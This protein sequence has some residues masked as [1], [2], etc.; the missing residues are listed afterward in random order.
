M[1]M[2]RERSGLTADGAC[3]IALGAFYNATARHP[4][5]GAAL[6]GAWMEEI[7]RKLKRDAAVGLDYREIIARWGAE[8]N[9]P[10]NA[11]F[12]TIDNRP[13]NAATAGAGNG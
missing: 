3:R 7:S 1:R 6:V 5:D 2:R 11:Q 9:T 8:E 10:N 13:D 12:A 4:R